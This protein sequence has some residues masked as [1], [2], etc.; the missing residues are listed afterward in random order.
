MRI[1]WEIIFLAIFYQFMQIIANKCK[2][3]CFKYSG[4]FIF[5]FAPVFLGIQN[6]L[7]SHDTLMNNSFLNFLYHSKTWIM[8]AVAI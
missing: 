8:E 2:N 4:M 7:P 3:V 1:P 6:I 5:I